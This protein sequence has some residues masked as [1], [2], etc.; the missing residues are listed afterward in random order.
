MTSL[1]SLQV[2]FDLY[3]SIEQYSS[4]E[5]RRDLLK[6]YLKKMYSQPNSTEVSKNV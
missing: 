2:S 3:P 1:L 6:L 5:Y 4:V